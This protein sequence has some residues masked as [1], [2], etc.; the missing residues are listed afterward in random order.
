MPVV[1]PRKQ[2]AAAAQLERWAVT[3][4]V[5]LRGFHFRIQ[6]RHRRARHSLPGCVFGCD[7]SDSES[8]SWLRLTLSLESFSVDDAPSELQIHG[9]M[10]SACACC[11][12]EYR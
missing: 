8:F 10:L 12:T 3:A 11:S 2:A 7:V 9:K 5:I 4:G 6:A 1:T